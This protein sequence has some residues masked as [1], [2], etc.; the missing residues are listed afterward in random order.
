MPN[1]PMTPEE[2]AELRGSHRAS[3]RHRWC[4]N[5]N[6]PDESPCTTTRLLDALEALTKERDVA[7]SCANINADEVARLSSKL[8]AAE[9]KISDMFGDN[10]AL[11]EALAALD[12]RSAE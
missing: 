7:I 6:C 2:I 3:I 5:P 4:S 9:A 10:M 11:Q 8:A 12:R 1:E